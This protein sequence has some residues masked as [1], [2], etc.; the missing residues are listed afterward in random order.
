MAGIIGTYKDW[1]GKDQC[2]VCPD[3][4]MLTVGPSLEEGEREVETGTERTRQTTRDR[5]AE[6][7]RQ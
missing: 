6:T 1:A 5:Q 7:D 4:N 2:L 3:S